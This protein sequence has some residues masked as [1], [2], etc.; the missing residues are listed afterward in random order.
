MAN[1]KRAGKYI[2]IG[3]ILT[4]FNF[5]VYTFLARVVFNNNELLWFDTIISYILATFLAYILHSKI[6]WKERVPSKIGVIKFFIW[7]IVTALIISPLFTW[8]FSLLTPLYEL[9]YNIFTAI[10]L[11]FDY[12]FVVS[13]GVF[14]LTTCVTMILNYLFYDKLV[15]GTTI[16][17][18]TISNKLLSGSK[19][20]SIIVP[21]YNSGKY[22][23]SCLNSII[24]QTYQNIEI[25][26][27]DDGSSDNSGKIADDYAKKDKRIKVIHQKNAGQ[28]N[29]RNAGIKK[30]TGDYISFVDSDDRITPNFIYD[31]LKLYSSNTSIAV[32]GHQYNRLKEKTTKNLY[33]HPLR[34]RHKNETIKAYI[35]QLLAKDGRMYSCNNKLFN[36]TTIKKYSIKFDE[37]LNFAEDTKFVLDY[38]QHAKGEIAYTPAPLY[39]YNFGTETSTI[40]K[41]ATVWQNWQTSYQNLKNWLGKTPSL[42]EKFWL[43][44]IHLRWRISYIRSK[45]RAK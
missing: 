13:T 15:F 7:N 35:L 10:H 33:Q 40:K 5:I 9:I 14:G 8:L 1:K 24:S 16:S 27:I 23:K 19:K 22:L 32:C 44:I 3:I 20:I 26:L 37:K 28:S 31:L 4:V 45:H 36:A 41:T 12:D 6:T 30:A 21:I 42:K 38:L 29:A 17:T 43:H 2:I 39:I 34:P 18:P 11:P 25:F